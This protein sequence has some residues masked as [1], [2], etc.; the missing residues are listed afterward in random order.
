MLAVTLGLTCGSTALTE[1]ER[2][3]HYST[4]DGNNQIVID[5]PVFPARIYNASIPIGGNVTITCPLQADHT[6]HVYIYG[7]WVHTGPEPKTDYDIYVYSPEGTMESSHT[8]AAGLPEHLG[9]TVDSPFFTPQKTGNY[10]FMLVNDARESNGAEPATFMIIE[11]IQCDTWYTYDVV[12]KNGSQATYYTN[13]AYEFIT[14]SALIEVYVKVPDTLDMYEARL[15]L[16]SDAQSTTIN[17][18]SLPWEPGLYGN[19]TG[20]GGYSMESESYRGVAYASCEYS[21]QDMYLN[22]TPATTEMTTYHLVLMGEV[23][24]GTVDFLVKTSFSGGLTSLTTPS[25][26]T[27]DDET[28]IAYQSDTNPLE[29]ATLQYTIDDWTNTTQLTMLVDNRTCNTTIPKQQAGSTVKYKVSATDSLKNLLSAEGQFIVKLDSAILDFNATKNPITLGTNIT[30]TGTV[31][32][33]AKGKPLEIQFISTNDTKRVECESYD[34]GT[35]TA[36]FQPE[37]SGI[38]TAQAF[39]KGNDK[40][41][42]CESAIVLV[43]VSEPTFIQK[44][45]VFVFA[46]IVGALGAGGAVYY[47]RKRRSG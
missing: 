33:A 1:Y 16:M 45:G 40:I 30:V 39:F 46:G 44:N 10:T 6:Y 11:N 28:P 7:D 21:G 14:D 5:K 43:T 32:A 20:L 27:P 34:N 8:E 13:W 47:V 26:V 25:R 17:N 37:T 42:P 23:G 2:Y 22:Y 36:Q 31:S 38:W 19:G 9:T 12:G 15:Y 35:F 24:E 4:Q 41:Y 29:N 18:V 3:V